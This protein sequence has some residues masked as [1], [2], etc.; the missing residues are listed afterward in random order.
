MF[1]NTKPYS[2][3]AVNNLQRAREFYSD[4]LRLRAGAAQLPR[5]EPAPAR[6]G[7]RAYTHGQGAAYIDL[8]TASSV[9]SLDGPAS[10]AGWAVPM[11]VGLPLIERRIARINHEEAMPLIADTQPGSQAVP[12]RRRTT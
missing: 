7:A 6:V 4:P 5:P 3:L 9:V 10:V 8:V 11:L 1:A 2:G 12:T